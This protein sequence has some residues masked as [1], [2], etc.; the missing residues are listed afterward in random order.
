MRAIQMMLGHADVATTEIYT[1]VLDTRLAE[2]VALSV[3]PPRFR[4]FV[5]FT[6]LTNA[7]LVRKFRP[8]PKKT[9]YYA[10]C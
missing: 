3:V 7:S 6:H 9:G 10:L 5:S 8:S 1:H 4:L 2:Q